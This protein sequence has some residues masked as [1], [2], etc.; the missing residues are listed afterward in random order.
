MVGTKEPRK[1]SNN[2]K[3]I[4]LISLTSNNNSSNNSNSHAMQQKIITIICL[5]GEALS[6]PKVSTTSYRIIIYKESQQGAA[7][8]LTTRIAITMSRRMRTLRIARQSTEMN[9]T[10]KTGQYTRANGK[11]K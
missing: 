2:D 9:F 1:K 8:H 5:E 7:W 6:R 4:W 11:D 3:L 10:L